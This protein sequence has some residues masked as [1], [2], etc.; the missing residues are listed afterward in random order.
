MK[1]NKAKTKLHFASM[2]R[3]VRIDSPPDHF[4]REPDEQGRSWK[5]NWR[6]Q[7]SGYYCWQPW[8]P[9]SSFRRWQYVKD[10]ERGPV[11]APSKTELIRLKS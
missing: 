11:A 8:G 1:T 6:G 2:F 10:Y 4:D 7:V 3:V 5:L 9:N